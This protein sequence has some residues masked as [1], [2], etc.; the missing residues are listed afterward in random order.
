MSLFYFT[1]RGILI[2]RYYEG[3][4]M[5]CF[6]LESLGLHLCPSV[7]ISKSISESILF[8]SQKCP[9]LETDYIATLLN[10]HPAFIKT[11][12]AY[13]VLIKYLRNILPSQALEFLFSVSLLSYVFLSFP[14]PPSI[15]YFFL[16]PTFF[17]AF[18]LVET[19][20]LAWT[21][22][23]TEGVQDLLMLRGSKKLR[24]VSELSLQ[25]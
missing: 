3:A 20:I 6:C 12:E 4:C 2:V 16:L 24:L 23:W 22:R 1:F 19:P 5:S 10:M 15:L 18:G 21:S 25:S 13:H 7:I 14:V 17:P 8:H 9:P 11:L